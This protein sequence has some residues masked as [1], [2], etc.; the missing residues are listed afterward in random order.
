MKYVID[1]GEPFI[2]ADGEVL[3]R[4]NGFN[5]LVFDEYGLQHLTKYK[6]TEAYQHGYKSGKKATQKKARNP[7]IVR[8][9]ANYE[10]LYKQIYEQN[11]KQNAPMILKCD[12]DDETKKKLDTA[13]E[14]ILRLE[15]E[16]NELRTQKDNSNTYIWNYYD[17]TT[18]K[19]DE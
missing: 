2:N 11:K 15:D 12:E 13:R 17:Y 1:I 14:K 19:E 4:A 6:D 9:K 7:Y 18:H 3:Y 16:L 8:L 10:Q 5:S